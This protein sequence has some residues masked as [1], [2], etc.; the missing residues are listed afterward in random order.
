MKSHPHCLPVARARSTDRPAKPIRRAPHTRAR[1]ARR[2]R[3]PN[4]SARH[5]RARASSLERRERRV[6]TESTREV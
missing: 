3:A 2:E 4:A 5:A 1:D 6:A